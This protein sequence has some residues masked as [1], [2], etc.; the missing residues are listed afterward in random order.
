MLDLSPIGALGD[1]NSLDDVNS[2]Q[3]ITWNQLK[4]RYSR[5]QLSFLTINARS[6]KNKFNEL[7]CQ[8]SLLNEKFNFIAITET[9]FRKNRVIYCDDII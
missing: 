3:F 6:L 5:C 7:L 9:H 8:L 4:S 2:S 1:Y